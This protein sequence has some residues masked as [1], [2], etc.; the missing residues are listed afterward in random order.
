MEIGAPG[1]QQSASETALLLLC[2]LAGASAAFIAFL[3]VL[4]PVLD[5]LR[6][7]REFGEKHK[8]FI[9]TLAT[10]WECS[11]DEA[12]RRWLEFARRSDALP[13]AVKQA[14]QLERDLRELQRLD[15]LEKATRR[16]ESEKRLEKLATACRTADLRLWVE[17][18]QQSC[19]D[20]I[21]AAIWVPMQQFVSAADDLMLDE[22][23]ASELVGQVERQFDARIAARARAAAAGNEPGERWIAITR[24]RLLAV[25]RDWQDLVTWSEG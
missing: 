8:K 2:L 24:R 10:Q 4:N 5:A 17:M 19:P 6:E 16:L 22:D 3:L 20:E 13:A 1:L 25:V 15:E 14:Q 9:A 21:R 18:A 12:Q 23:L 11:W 7:Y